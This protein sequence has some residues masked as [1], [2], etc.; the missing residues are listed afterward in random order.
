M[1][2]T[3]SGFHLLDI[4]AEVPDPR[5]KKGKRHPLKAILGLIVIGLMCNQKSYT[6][7]ATWGRTQPKL[8]KALDSEMPKRLVRQRFIT[9]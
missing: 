5:K 4:L 3:P 9:S 6:A 2:R 7:I 8:A 1:T